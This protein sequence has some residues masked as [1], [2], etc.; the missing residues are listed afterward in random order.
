MD[1]WAK[2]YLAMLGVAAVIAVC[3]PPSTFITNEYPSTIET[4]SVTETIE[5][6]QIRAAI[7]GELIPGGA[8]SSEIRR[9][10]SEYSMELSRNSGTLCPEIVFP[11]TQP[12]VVT[13]GDSQ[14]LYVQLSDEMKEANNRI[15]AANARIGEVA[16]AVNAV[17]QLAYEAKGYA[18]DSDRHAVDARNVAERKTIV[19]VAIVVAAWVGFVYAIAGC[20]MAII[21]RRKNLLDSRR[22][23]PPGPKQKSRP[24]AD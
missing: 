17:N 11:T 13:Q 16:D 8:I 5:Q 14:C 7:A 4:V 23:C 22:I 19:P 9:S 6:G 3:F 18:L 15:E 24:R 2:I 20:L 21:K 12:V 10:I 1:V